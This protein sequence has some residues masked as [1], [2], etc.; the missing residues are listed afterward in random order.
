MEIS[1]LI[2]KLEVEYDELEAGSL[3]SNSSFSEIENWGSMHSLILIALADT[4]YDVVISGS[5][6]KTISTVQDLFDIIQIKKK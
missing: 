5:D 6:L 1:E 4:E 3:H 2:E